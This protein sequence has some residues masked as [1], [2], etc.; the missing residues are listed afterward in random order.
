MDIKEEYIK[1]IKLC[2]KSDSNPHNTGQLD[3]SS[4]IETLTEELH[5]EKASSNILEK[6]MNY[7]RSKLPN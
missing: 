3:M 5:E 1:E 4:E 6:I 2:I 7:L